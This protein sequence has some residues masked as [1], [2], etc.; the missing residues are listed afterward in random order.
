MNY[1]DS[2]LILSA[3]EI[4]KMNDFLTSIPAKIIAKHKKLGF[5]ENLEEE[6][7]V[8]QKIGLDQAHTLESNS[9]RSR[10]VFKET[11]DDRPKSANISQRPSFNSIEVELREMEYLKML[12]EKDPHVYR[13]FTKQKVTP[14][15]FRQWYS[16]SNERVAMTN[17]RK[18]V[19]KELYDPALSSTFTPYVSEKSRILATQAQT[20]ASTKHFKSPNR[21]ERL[22]QQEQERLKKPE[23]K[24]NEKEFANHMKKVNTWNQE[25]YKKNIKRFVADFM[26]T[27]EIRRPT[28]Q[29]KPQVSPAIENIMGHSRSPN[30]SPQHIPTHRD[31]FQNH[32]EGSDI[33]ARVSPG[34]SFG[35]QK[36]V[37]GHSKR[38]EGL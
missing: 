35:N 33:G 4:K 34:Y 27:S 30:K 13:H 2:N 12:R 7:K 24:F 29:N 8:M 31:Y 1:R 38:N 21:T 25:V 5:L 19:M 26:A 28:P 10:N 3:K 11:A 17:A 6:A 22:Q 23:R 36:S 14:N 16:K 20:Y 37:S 15:R 9:I 18:D 32:K